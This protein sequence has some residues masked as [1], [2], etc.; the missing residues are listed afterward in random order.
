MT[1]TLPGMSGNISWHS[2]EQRMISYKAI[3]E[4]NIVWF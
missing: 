3:V 4:E 2:L 1:E